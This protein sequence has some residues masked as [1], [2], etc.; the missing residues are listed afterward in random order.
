[1]ARSARV[2]S[3]AFPFPLSTIDHSG[4]VLSPAAHAHIAN[5]F[6]LHYFIS[7]SECTVGPHVLSFGFN[8]ESQSV[9]HL[10]RYAPGVFPVVPTRCVFRE[11][12]YDSICKKVMRPQSLTAI[13]V[14]PRRSAPSRSPSIAPMQCVPMFNAIEVARNEDDGPVSGNNNIIKVLKQDPHEAEVTFQVV[15]NFRNNKPVEVLAVKYTD[16]IT[17]EKVCSER[18]NVPSGPVAQL[19]TAQCTD[20]IA[21]VVVFA[22]DSTKYSDITV[23][24]SSANTCTLVD[25]PNTLA[26]TYKVPCHPGCG[27]EVSQ[28]VLQIFCLGL[29]NSSFDTRRSRSCYRDMI[30]LRSPPAPDYRSCC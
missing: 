19:F 25:R 10:D 9:S 12:A 7:F 5:L 2:R 6:F 26:I 1:L 28:L 17:G 18:E 29:F 4:L 3:R 27:V 21:Q 8:N 13:L 30:A 16:S 15:Q 22:R 14:S 11:C 24:P 20:S 23:A